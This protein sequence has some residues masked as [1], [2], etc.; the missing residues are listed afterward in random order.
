MKM[1]VEELIG[2]LQMMD[3]KAEV[4][5]AVQPSYPMQNEVRSELVEAEGVVY[6]AD[7]GQVRGAPYLPGEI[8]EAFGWGR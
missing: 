2:E 3:G 7:A 6:I 5:L 4:R 1:T 8:A